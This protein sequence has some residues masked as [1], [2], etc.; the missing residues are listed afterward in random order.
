VHILDT[1]TLTHLHAGHP[2]VIQCLRELAD[3]L[4]ATTII[5]KIELL[6]GRFDYLLRAATGP[7]LLRAQQRLA[8]TEELLAQIPVLF[9]DEQAAERFDQLRTTPRLGR[10]G[11]A[12]LL[13]ASIALSYRAT[14]VTRNVSH[15]RQV[16]GLNVKNWVD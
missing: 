11:R 16:I 9:L 7:E 15:F 13:I 4:V 6:R 10:I 14:L 12:D 1:D 2:R 5:T 8:R 3:P